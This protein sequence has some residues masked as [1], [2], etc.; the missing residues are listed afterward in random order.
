MPSYICLKR[1]GWVVYVKGNRLS[2]GAAPW[3][4]QSGD[5]RAGLTNPNHKI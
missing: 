5:P 3:E 4:R 1:G 2:S